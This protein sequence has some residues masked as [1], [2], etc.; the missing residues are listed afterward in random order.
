[1]LSIDTKF[2]IARLL[3]TKSKSY[4]SIFCRIQSDFFEIQHQGT[5]DKRVDKYELSKAAK[6]KT[7]RVKVK[8]ISVVNYWGKL[9]PLPETLTV[10]L[11]INTAWSLG[12]EVELPTL[13]EDD[14]ALRFEP[15]DIPCDNSEDDDKMTGSISVK[16]RKQTIW[17]FLQITDIRYIGMV[18]I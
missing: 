18:N 5:I 17:F 9:I 3:V 1:M 2:T 7:N 11:T 6:W 14:L 8:G 16:D 15:G 13:K 10:N 4:R 12:T